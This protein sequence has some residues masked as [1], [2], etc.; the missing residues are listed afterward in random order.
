[1]AKKALLIYANKDE[2]EKVRE[3]GDQAEVVNL[4]KKIVLNG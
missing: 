1:L 4:V 3:T 2:L